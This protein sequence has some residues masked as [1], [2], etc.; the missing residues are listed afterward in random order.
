VPKT[1]FGEKFINLIIP[2]DPSSEPLA[3]GDTIG[4]DRSEVAIETGKVFDDILPLLRT[5]Q[6]VKLN[7]TLNAL[8]TALEGRGNALGENFV[9]A[10]QYF[11]DFN[12]NLDTFNQDISGLAD[13]A[14]SLGD[15]APDLLRLA[16][17][18]ASS[19]QEVVVAKQ[20]TFTEFLRGTQGFATTLTRVLRD[21]ESSFV[22][23]ADNSRKILGVFEKYSPEF[24][25]LLRGLTDIQ[26][27]VE[28]TFATGP[29]LYVHLEALPPQ[30]KRY[31]PGADEPTYANYG[32]ANCNGLP[33]PGD[34]TPNYPSPGVSSAE[35]EANA[36]AVG[37]RAY[38]DIGPIGSA[39]EID[40]INALAGALMN[41]P[42]DDVDSV[43]ALLLGPL[44]RGME[45]DLR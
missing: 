39:N 3:D 30:S 34:N 4:Q 32:P 23:L 11:R 27:R 10:D 29:Y 17:N 12:P 16:A 44:V 33:Q 37:Q 7:A 45:A 25:C 13:L 8:A 9:L 18:S 21:N 36:A 26:K 20:D 43:A 15:A 19:L 40:V 22:D 31:L 5:L 24:P 41:R 6:P 42:V 38:G 14:D 35:V 28:A 1:L 2:E